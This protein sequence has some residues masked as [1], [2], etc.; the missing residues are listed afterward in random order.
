MALAGFW[1]QL[2]V[3]LESLPAI[4]IYAAFRD[5]H[6]SG[7][8]LRLIV[9][10]R[11]YLPSTCRCLYPRIVTYVKGSLKEDGVSRPI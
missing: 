11:P 1:N 8:V 9:N 5:A 7:K 2:P 6:S 4:Q 3:S 10:H